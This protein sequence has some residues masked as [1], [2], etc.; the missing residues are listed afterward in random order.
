VRKI[1]LN[2]SFMPKNITGLGVYANNII[3]AFDGIESILFSPRNVRN[4]KKSFSKTPEEISSD[5]GAVGNIKR[6]IWVE[7]N[8]RKYAKDGKCVI[9]SPIPE[10]PI[11]SGRKII[12]VHDLIPLKNEFASL[13][14]KMYFKHYVLNVIKKADLVISDSQETKRDILKYANI[15]ADRVSVIPLGVNTNKFRPAVKVLKEGYV[16]YVGRH[17][18]YKNID[19]AI[20]AFSRIKNKEIKFRIVG[21]THKL[22][23]PRLQ[24]LCNELRIEN[25]VIFES[26]VNFDRLVEIMQKSLVLIH[27]SAYEGFG[28]TVLEAMAANT[29]VICA[30]GGALAE[31]VG[32][33]AIQCCPENIEEI[34]E[35]INKVVDDEKIREDLEKRGTLHVGDWSWDK[36]IQSVKCLVKEFA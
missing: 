4:Q 35:I 1:I 13:K 8:L 18:R 25:R 21:P 16:T 20:M 27:L 7:K 34:S 15:G 31:V 28:L 29:A 17:D 9:F 3:P 23:T 2:Y 26:Y 11:F 19:K 10:A 6:I 22:E 32:S 5:H 24:K 36:S 14:L 30:A 33:A 12:V